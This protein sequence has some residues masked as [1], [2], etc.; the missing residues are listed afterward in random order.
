M[1]LYDQ[2]VSNDAYLSSLVNELPNSS[3]EY[4]EKAFLV[5]FE[6]NLKNDKER[7]SSSCVSLQI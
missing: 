4:D 1:S 2:L 3:D 6:Q 5:R 7:P